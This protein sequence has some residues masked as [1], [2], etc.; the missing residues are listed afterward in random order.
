[1]SQR[2][3]F[4]KLALQEG[5]N[6]SELCRRFSI[7]RPTGY[8]FLYRYQQDGYQGLCDRSKRPK[9]SPHIT[10]KEIEQVILMLRDK[11]PAWGGRKL[12]RRLEDLGHTDLP[13]PSTI[14][15]ILKRNNRISIEESKKRETWHRFEAERPNDLWQMDFKGYFQAQ[16]GRCHPLT[17]L[18]D[19]SRYSLCVGAC[20]NEVRAIVKQH[21]ID[22][23]RKYGIPIR[24]LMDNGPPWGSDSPTK[25]TKLT[26]W[27]MR[28][29][30][31]IIHSRPY[32]PQTAGKDERFHRTLKAE[33]LN[34][35]KNKSINQCQKVF[36]DWRNVY[37]TE[38]PHEALGM[39]TPVSR[40]RLS[41][42]QYPEK[43]PDTEYGPNDEIRKVCVKGKISYKNRKFIVGKAFIGQYIAI[44][45]TTVDGKYT[46]HFAN[47]KVGHVDLTCNQ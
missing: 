2:F 46:I 43:I 39:N 32:H 16:D 17:V 4:V 44:R 25:F 37:N 42:R 19:H 10:A 47:Q 9:H 33:V 12:K 8:K 5:V 20:R 27:L 14:T 18:D 22:V 45:P 1:M 6:F 40:Y 3:E 35:C 28:V 24:M 11:H 31:K 13:F 21:L 23:F 29:G 34:Y 38:R 15:Q 26:V 36:D 7:S 30:I 41:K